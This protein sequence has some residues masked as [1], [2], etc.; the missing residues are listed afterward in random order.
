MLGMLGLVDADDRDVA[1]NDTLEQSAQ[2]HL[3]RVA[4][5]VKQSK[6]VLQILAA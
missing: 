2:R 4:L 1:W 5:E 6:A 3:L